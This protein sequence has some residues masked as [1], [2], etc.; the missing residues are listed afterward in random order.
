MT[1]DNDETKGVAQ[2]YVI[3]ANRRTGG[4]YLAHCL[5]NHPQVFCDRG[6]SVHHMALWRKYIPPRKTLHVLTHQEGYHASGF[7]MVYTQAF[8]KRIWTHLP[9]MKPK[10]I[11]LTREN[12]LR[13]GVS[14]AVNSLVRK[15]KLT[16]Y[17]V[18]TFKERPAPRYDI[19]PDHI[20]KQCIRLTRDDR[21][22]AKRFIDAQMD[23]LPV[24]YE[25][26][27]GKDGTTQPCVL[28]STMQR[29][30]DYLGV[31]RHALCCDLKRVH[32]HPLS[33]M[34]RNWKEVKRAIA[35]TEFAHY[36][37]EEEN[38]AQDEKGRWV[39]RHD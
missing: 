27:V 16:Y 9:Q 38:W 29:I 4:T 1:I 18:H 36:L 33:A 32:G 12:I 23:Y 5:S 3:I 30:C 14:V 24:T 13:Q 10:V 20:I 37:L 11:W 21:W 35:K 8:H 2:P 15:G 26:L 25:D 31:Y 34:L 19:P 6:E 7:R 28:D 22:A 39:K 17:P